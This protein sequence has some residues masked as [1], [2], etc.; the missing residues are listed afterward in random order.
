MKLAISDG[1]SQGT[2][3]MNWQTDV[4]EDLHGK[5]SC[6]TVQQVV[7]IVM[8]GQWKLIENKTVFPQKIRL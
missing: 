1:A 3:Q 7:V 4:Y 2:L 6:K 8:N 5:E